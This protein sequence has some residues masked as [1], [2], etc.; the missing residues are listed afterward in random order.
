MK[1]W[2][3]VGWIARSMICDCVRTVTLVTYTAVVEEDEG[4]LESKLRRPCGRQGL[5]KGSLGEGRRSGW[6]GFGVWD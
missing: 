4:P 6:R 3:V 1:R 2:F 5:E